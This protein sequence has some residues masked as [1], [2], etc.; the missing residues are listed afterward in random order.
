MI[1]TIAILEVKIEL[2]SV[3]GMFHQPNDWVNHLQNELPA[4]YHPEVR[5]IR[6]EQKQ[7]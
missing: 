5:L 3:P 6:I 1:K 7:S 4:W 2:D